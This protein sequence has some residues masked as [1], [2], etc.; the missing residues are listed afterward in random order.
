VRVGSNRRGALTALTLAA[1]LSGCAN[2]SIFDSNERW[3]SKPFTIVSRNGGYTYSELQDAQKIRTITASDLVDASG[4]CP[5][6]PMAATALPPAA[7]EGPGA[8]PAASPAAPSLMGDGIALG[9]SECDVVYRAGAASAVQLG[10]NPNGDRTA[11][12][13]FNSGPRPGIYRFERGRLMDMDRVAVAE[14]PPQQK[15]AK[16]KKRPPGKPQKISTE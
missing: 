9:M 2:S 15:V 7:A 5:P 14:P 10:N 8:T 13:T 12:L 16:K 6:A 1:V 11:L 3:F 4:A